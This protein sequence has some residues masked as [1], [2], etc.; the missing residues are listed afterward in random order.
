M[1]AE[2]WIKQH[3]WYS[4]FVGLLLL[5]SF[6]SVLTSRGTRQTVTV[7]D[8]GIASVFL[9]AKTGHLLPLPD[10]HVPFTLE[11]RNGR[12]TFVVRDK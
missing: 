11:K 4:A 10:R 1:K 7:P 6:W 9:I 2:L 8:T 12:Y 3:S 5:L